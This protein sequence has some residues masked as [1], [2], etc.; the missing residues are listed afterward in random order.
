M[1]KNQF[2]SMKALLTVN[3]QYLAVISA[4]GQLQRPL[5]DEEY[6]QCSADVRLIADLLESNLEAGVM[7]P[8]TWRPPFWRR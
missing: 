7:P 4:Q 8:D 6:D 2:E 5:T 1:D 3:A